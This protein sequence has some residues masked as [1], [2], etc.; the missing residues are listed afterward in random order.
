M[1]LEASIASL[2]KWNL[3]AIAAG[4]FSNKTNE[5]KTNWF[6]KNI[7]TSMV[8]TKNIRAI[9][10]FKQICELHIFL[11]SPQ[12]SFE[13]WRYL[14]HL[15]LCQNNCISR[16][17]NPTSIQ[18]ARKQSARNQKVLAKCGISVQSSLIVWK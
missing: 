15:V 3:L 8:L 7:F 5:Q 2:Q 9:N 18:S 13:V 12:V 6:T 1:V 11:L 16:L 10:I 4:C 14:E 17:Y